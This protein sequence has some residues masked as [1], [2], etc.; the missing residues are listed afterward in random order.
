[1]Y[2]MEFERER[3]RQDTFLKDE[4]KRVKEESKNKLFS[5]VEQH[6]VGH[7]SH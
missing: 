4:V 3:N 5:I 2:R 6:K 1:M 7:S